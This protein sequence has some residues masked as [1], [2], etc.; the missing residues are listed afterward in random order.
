MFTAN[1]PAQQRVW[2]VGDEF[3]QSAFN[4]FEAMKNGN[5]GYVPYLFDYYNV[6]PFWKYSIGS[7]VRSPLARVVNSL[8]EAINSSKN[9]PRFIIFILERDV[10]KKAAF[11]DYGSSL[12][13]G[14]SL[15]WLIHQVTTIVESRKID[16]KNK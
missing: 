16:L 4:S 8:I 5:S 10:L 2:L 1:V 12:V 7:I 3:L 11:Y 9:L 13:I 14:N 15:R 6:T